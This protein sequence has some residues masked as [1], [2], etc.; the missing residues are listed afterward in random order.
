MSERGYRLLEPAV[1]FYEVAHEMDAMFEG[2]GRDLVSG[3]GNQ[4]RAGAAEFEPVE[5]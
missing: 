2:A 3:G 1:L 4:A 5:D